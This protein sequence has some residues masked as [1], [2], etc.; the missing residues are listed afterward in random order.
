MNKK[1]KEKIRFGL[2]GIHADTDE[3]GY[4]GLGFC[5][6]REG[7]NNLVNFIAE[8]EDELKLKEGEKIDNK[9]IEE[10]ISF[11]WKNGSSIRIVYYPNKIDGVANSD[12]IQL[13]INPADAKERGWIMNKRDA[14]NIIWGLSKAIDRCMDDNIPDE[15]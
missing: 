2:M 8:R 3:A 1:E 5:I 6:S 9:E 10:V 12:R 14:I 11:V 7:M 4:W 15:E 13:L